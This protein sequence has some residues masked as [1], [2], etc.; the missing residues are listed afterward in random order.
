MLSR[1]NSTWLFAPFDELQAWHRSHRFSMWSVTP[2]DRSTTIAG[3]FFSPGGG[4]FKV[5][6]VNRIGNSNLSGA[7]LCETDLFDADLSGVNLEIA[8]LGC[9]RLA[10]RIRSLCRCPRPLMPAIALQQSL[11]NQVSAHT[12]PSL[13]DPFP[14][15]AMLRTGVWP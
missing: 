4:A 14:S 3:H 2:Y 7:G 9:A 6:T 15:S 1:R 5:E 11:A 10:G 12:D 8:D 13:L